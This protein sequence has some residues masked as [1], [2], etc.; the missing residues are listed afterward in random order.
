VV[1]R[2]RASLDRVI[3]ARPS[4]QRTAGLTLKTM[5]FYIVEAILR[6][7]VRTCQTRQKQH[8]YIGREARASRSG[9]GVSRFCWSDLLGKP[10]HWIEQTCSSTFCCPRGN[11]SGGVGPC[12]GG[13]VNSVGK[14]L[15]VLS[16]NEAALA[17]RLPRLSFHAVSQPRCERSGSS[18]GPH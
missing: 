2:Y 13:F 14:S 3:R 4:V 18:E 5:T 11:G 17:A 8:V 7:I 6:N 9:R 1:P 10:S 12:R 15:I 16:P